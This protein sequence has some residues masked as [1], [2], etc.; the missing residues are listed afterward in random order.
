MILVRFL[1]G[2]FKRADTHVGTNTRPL[3]GIQYDGI[4]NVVVFAGRN[5]TLRRRSCREFADR[6]RN[7]IV[8]HN[9]R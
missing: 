4:T 9:K 7:Y 2:S 8:V 6:K 3:F 1:D 5:S